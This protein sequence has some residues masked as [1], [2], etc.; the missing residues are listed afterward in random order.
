MFNPTAIPL[1]SGNDIDRPMNALTLTQNLHTLFGRFEITFKY[2][3]PHTY[4]IDYVK[5][6]RLLQIVK[7]PVTRTLY[8][9]PDRNIDPPSVDLL[10]IHHTIAKILHLSAAGE[11][12]DKFLRD[13]EEMEG[14]QV[15]S[16]GTSRIDE[17]VRFKL[18]GCLDG[19]FEEMSVC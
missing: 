6:D 17:Y 5:Q 14:G 13:M 18:A 19:C 8:L 7:L 11:F 9:T 2:I 12:I 4:K 16:N 3:G 15:M 10:K 1:I